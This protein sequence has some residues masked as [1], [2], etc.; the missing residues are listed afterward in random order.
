MKKRTLLFAAIALVFVIAFT[1]AIKDHSGKFHTAGLP[2]PG[3]TTC[4]APACHGA[5]NG[6][7]TSGGFADNAGP[8][9]IQ[10]TSSNMTGWVYTPGTTY[11]MTIT[12]TDAAALLF[13]F[14]ASIV[15]NGGNNAGTIII[16]DA[17]HTRKGTQPGTTNNIVYIT[18]VGPP[19]SPNPSYQ[20]ITSNP[21]VIIFDWT[22]PATNVGPV[23]F[24]YDGVAANNNTWEDA[25]D[26]TY[27]GSQIV[28][29]NSASSLLLAS[30]TSVP[31]FSS[32]IGIA[33]MP[34]TITVGGG[35]LAGSV[36]VNAPAQFQV[37][38]TSS[39][40]FASSLVLPI[41]S[42]TLA[43]TILYVQYL[44]SSASTSG[45]ITLTDGVT[46]SP[47]IA[48]S[49][50][51]TASATVFV[52]SLISNSYRT[53]V[54]YPSVVKNFTVSGINLTA[55]LVVTALT[56]Y[57]VS[58]SSGSGFANSV[59]ITPTSGNVA[60]TTIYIR[61]NPSAAGLHNGLV[62]ISSTGATTKYITIGGLSV[63]TAV[64]NHT[65]TINNFS[66]TVGTPSSS[67]SFNIS[68]TYLK[69]D[70]VVTAPSNFEVSL[71]SGSG[72]GSSVSVAQISGNLASTTIYVR[73]NPISAGTQ[74]GNIV[75][76]C[77]GDPTAPTIALSGT[78]TNPVSPTIA[79][80]NPPTAFSATVGTPST[81]QISNVSG[82]NLTSNI[83][84]T[85]PTDFEVSLTSGTGFGS[86]VN[87]IPSSGAVSSTPIYIR[88][89][90]ASPG[91]T[92]ST[93]SL[94]STGASTQNISVSGNSSTTATIDALI[95]NANLN[96]YPNPL[97]GLGYISFNLSNSGQVQINLLNYQG[98]FVKEIYNNSL[99]GGIAK[100]PFDFAGLTKGVYLIEIQTGDNSIRKLVVAE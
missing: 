12:I 65:G 73:Y 50:S 72:F 37:S 39:S 29:P 8:G 32:V 75:L 95:S 52:N 87:L 51:T 57:E 4:S 14:S 43:T 89:N 100:I 62:P 35:G 41:S 20:T 10:L 81:E 63:V 2:I 16:T 15:D 3:E 46:T 67:Q 80:N 88:Y 76:S 53:V 56:N 74:S 36:T 28:T 54:G 18:H 96:I 66:T 97:N 47:N 13:G 40:G 38:L 6:S 1:K 68:G 79:T 31:A 94:T 77:V 91:T 71:T 98:Q 42:G 61:Y 44:P 90:P 78:S 49:G 22:A 58:L 9:N 34:Q 85:A 82:L 59:S 25:G 7:F 21:A 24:Y 69:W 11:H 64:I 84:I 23:T 60:P 5:G 45:N 17:T 86:S 48:V 83:V 92:T 99:G 70:A 27:S 26:N 33:S 93:I 30:P 55:N 19:T